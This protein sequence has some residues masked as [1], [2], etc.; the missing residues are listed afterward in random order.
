MLIMTTEILSQSELLT[1]LDPHVAAVVSR[2]N[3]RPEL[4]AMME[5]LLNMDGPALARARRSISKAKVAPPAAPEIDVD[6]LQDHRARQQNQI[7]AGRDVPG[8]GGDG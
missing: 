4:A 7:E 6:V 5:Q 2:L 8:P 1:P 3:E